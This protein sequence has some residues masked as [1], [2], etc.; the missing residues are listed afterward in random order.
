MQEQLF[1]VLSVFAE[2]GPE[3]KKYLL[4]FGMIRLLLN[5]LFNDS[6]FTMIKFEYLKFPK[7][8]RVLLLGNDQK[9][10]Q[11]SKLEQEV[12]VLQNKDISPYH[13]ILKTISVL[14]WSCW[15]DG[16][17]PAAFKFSHNKIGEEPIASI[18]R[19][20]IDVLMDIS[21]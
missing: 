20:D 17:D 8:S 14:V 5:Y 3:A 12:A 7:T 2:L 13:F 11:P 19:Q 16:K 15:L 6:T 18:S 10:E 1:W 4:K 21:K 9:W